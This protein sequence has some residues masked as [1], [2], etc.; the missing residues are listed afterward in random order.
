MDELR[1]TSVV[2]MR[3]GTLAER[4]R[5]T[6]SQDEA[7]ANRENSLISLTTCVLQTSTTDH[8]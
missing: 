5:R 8:K 6:A 1:G 2:I 4:A 3:G 7:L